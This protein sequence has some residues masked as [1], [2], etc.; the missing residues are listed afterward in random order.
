MVS[1][2]VSLMLVNYLEFGMGGEMGGMMGIVPFNLLVNL[3]N[4]H[5][6]NK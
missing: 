6:E 3:E 1:F 5:A 4:M 2:Y